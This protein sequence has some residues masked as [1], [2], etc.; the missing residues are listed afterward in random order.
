VTLDLEIKHKH[1]KRLSAKVSRSRV[2]GIKVECEGSEHLLSSGFGEEVLI[3]ET[4][5]LA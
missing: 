3:S 1:L 4:V 5:K 2:S